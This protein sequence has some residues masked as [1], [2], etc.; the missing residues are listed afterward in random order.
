MYNYVINDIAI[1]GLANLIG[2]IT[3][4]RR[5]N[6]YVLKRLDRILYNEVVI[7][8]ITGRPYRVQLEKYIT[9]RNILNSVSKILND[10]RVGRAVRKG[11]VEN[12]ITKSVIKSLRLRNVKLNSYEISY[13]TF[14]T[15]SPAKHCNLSCR[16][17]YANSTV[18]DSDTL[19]YD[20]FSRVVKEKTI[21]WG[22]HF[23]VISGGEPLTYRS[24]G[25]DI[26][27]FYAEHNDNF[28]LMY[29]NG[30]L[31]DRDMA[32]RLSEVGNCTPAVSVEGF[33]KITD[34]RRGKGVYKKTVRAMENMIDYGVPFGLSLTATR[35]N[36]KEILSEEFL[37]F[38]IYKMGAKYMWIFQYMPIGRHFTLELMLTPEERL[39]MFKREQEILHSTD[40][41]FAD[42]WNSGPVSDGCIA[43]GRFGGYLHLLWNGDITPCV[44]IP[45]KLHNI[46]DVY[47]NG[48][49]LDTTL[50]SPLFKKIR[51]W[52]I[53]YSF[54]KKGSDM[55]NQI[56]P[57]LI[58]DHHKE[59]MEIIKKTGAIPIDKQAEQALRDDKYHQ[60]LIEYDE[61]FARL[62]NPIWENEYLR[63]FLKEENI[64]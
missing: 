36:Y 1:K 16:G 22:S 60:G 45:Y 35:E 14:I 30:T 59:F 54:M 26:I 18:R 53:E 48:G 12:L 38:F 8:N 23:T 15:I 43:G 4:S 57:C 28:F 11:V 21:T 29:T 55:E 34:K 47:K 40:I 13:P 10:K 50:N 6:D 17:C 52:Q 31:I 56:M 42:F 62:T 3:S 27:D 25:K 24:K 41:F 19:D 5:L 32:K 44:F 51:E 49:N 64:G 7:K 2:Y 20:I 39:W 61:K 9:A 37:D 63:S 46:Y 58:R 33:E